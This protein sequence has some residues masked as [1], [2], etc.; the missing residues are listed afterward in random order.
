MLSFLQELQEQ[1]EWGA[2]AEA[3][4]GHIKERIIISDDASTLSF[5]LSSLVFL[6]LIQWGS[7]FMVVP[8]SVVV[9]W[10]KFKKL[11]AV[12]KISLT[13]MMI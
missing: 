5:Y 6:E 1:G 7:E 4:L 11:R 8:F 3:S 2:P 13:L 9:W 12:A 10:S